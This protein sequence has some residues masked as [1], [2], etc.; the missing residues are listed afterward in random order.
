MNFLHQEDWKS[1]WILTVVSVNQMNLAAG[2]VDALF[3]T[4]FLINI[5]KM[6]L[7]LWYYNVS[8]NVFVIYCAHV[9]YVNWYNYK[10]VYLFFVSSGLLCLVL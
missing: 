5:S 7:I 3:F 8:V 6:M 2:P 1:V 4:Y 10:P 9:H